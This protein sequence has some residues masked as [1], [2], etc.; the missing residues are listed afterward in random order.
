[1]VDLRLLL[2]SIHPDDAGRVQASI[3]SAAEAQ[4]PATVTCRLQHLNGETRWV[5][6]QGEPLGDA[7]K[8]LVGTIVDVTDLHR[9]ETA[10]G[11]LEERLAGIEEIG[12]VHSYEWDAR[13]DRIMAPEEV[14]TLL[15]L[16]PQDA[17]DFQ[18]FLDRL[19]PKERDKVREEVQGLL[20]RPDRFDFTF[21]LVLPDGSIRW[22]LSRG[23]S[24]VDPDGTAT[25][26]TGILLDVTAAK[27]AEGEL[28]RRYADVQK[29]LQKLRSLFDTLP[30][31]FAILDRELRFF[32][33]N[34]AFG[35]LS[36]LDPDE[37]RGRSL[38][39]VLPAA[40]AAELALRDAVRREARFET[41]AV[42]LDI[43]AREAAGSARVHCRTIQDEAGLLV[44]FGL[45][46]ESRSP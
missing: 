6:L 29:H 38:F 11:R 41:F 37:H 28:R 24:L 5:R 2:A 31:G 30:V 40:A 13:V 8:L 22:F 9:A 46:V 34:P 18:R 42:T 4:A 39:D 26:I 10:V 27:Q 33:V 20:L 7:P 43:P 17:F 3:A 16:A 32:E 21:R 36:G 14:R 44:G 35:A 23:R 19:L 15:G 45:I 1:L 12:G 25:G